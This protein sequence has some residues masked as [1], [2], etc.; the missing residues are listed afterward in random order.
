MLSIRAYE[1]TYIC[2]QNDSIPHD[3]K[4]TLGVLVSSEEISEEFSADELH[5]LNL[6]SDEIWEAL[7]ALSR[8][9]ILCSFGLN[10]YRFNDDASWMI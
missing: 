8:R 4:A 6:N 3:E 2:L 5:V 9:G 7:E 1:K 10:K